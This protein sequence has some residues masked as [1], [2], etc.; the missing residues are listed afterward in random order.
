M[1]LPKDLSALLSVGLLGLA[2]VNT[3]AAG[4]VDGGRGGRLCAGLKGS[5]VIVSFLQ[6]CIDRF[7]LKRANPFGGLSGAG[8]PG[9]PVQRAKGLFT[10]CNHQQRTTG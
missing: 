7:W 1:C 5:R 10:A 4:E 3:L 9:T 8:E 2:G 6:M